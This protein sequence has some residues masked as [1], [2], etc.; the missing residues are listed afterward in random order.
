[1]AYI[2]ESNLTSWIDTIDCHLYGDAFIGALQT[3]VIGNEV[4]INKSAI[5]NIQA[6]QLTS[7]TNYL[8]AGIEDINSQITS[9]KTANKLLRLDSNSKFIADIKNELIETKQLIITDILNYSKIAKLQIQ[10]FRSSTYAILKADTSYFNLFDEINNIIQFHGNANST[11]KLF[12]PIS[13]SSSDISSIV[14]GTNSIDFSDDVV[15]DINL[16]NQNIEAMGKGVLPTDN[17]NTIF[18]AFEVT[19][20]ARIK[21]GYQTISSD[22]IQQSSTN[23][24]VSDTQINTWNNKID[25]TFIPAVMYGNETQLNNI[26][27]GS[28]LKFSVTRNPAP[29][30][31]LASTTIGTR[32][33]PTTQNMDHGLIFE[34][35]TDGTRHIKAQLLEVT[36]ELYGSHN[37]NPDDYATL[38]S[39]QITGTPT[40]P[41]APVSLNS[42]SLQIANISYVFNAIQKSDEDKWVKFQDII[43]TLLTNKFHTYNPDD[44]LI[45]QNIFTA[46]NANLIAKG[47][48]NPGFDNTSYATAKW[49]SENMIKFGSGAAHDFIVRIPVTYDTIWLKVTN[50]RWN[51]YGVKH[52]TSTPTPTPFNQGT[53]NT[54]AR[55]TAGYRKLVNFTPDGGLPDSATSTHKWVPIPIDKDKNNT[56][57]TINGVSCREVTI[58][59]GYFNYNGA[60]VTPGDNWISG[61]AF[62]KNPFKHTSVSGVGLYWGVNNHE[63]SGWYSESWNNDNLAYFLIGGVR[64]FRIPVVDYLNETEDRLFYVVGHN[65]NWSSL[66]H[67]SLTCNGQPMERLRTT[68][69]NPF[70]KHF[71]S[72]LYSNYA[73]ARIPASIIAS[74][75]GFLTFTIDVTRNNDQ[76]YF[77]ELGIHKFI[78]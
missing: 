58:Y 48:N 4:D 20:D 29:A 78:P 23:Q 53:S 14:I 42:G 41:T 38:N 34:T 46:L 45:Y 10:N 36:S 13:I 39:P 66:N 31:T 32:I 27:Q 16:K 24:M 17:G 19:P 52:G 30:G 8:K 73:A 15:L 65:D 26:R 25:N 12:N 35:P 57:V 47:L 49:N 71:N 60:N 63:R 72:H 2:K 3:D 50:D 77:R 68:Y 61:L 28:V 5:A 37:F 69:I 74:C 44:C 55:Y 1:M 11:S 22:S 40:V 9:T 7:R 54:L 64:T 21:T 6:F 51:I 18:Y 67:R 75:D 76:F 56:L 43:T 59:S 70:E 62:S 33:N